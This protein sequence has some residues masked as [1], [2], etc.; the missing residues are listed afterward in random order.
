M[1]QDIFGIV[2]FILGLF[3][4]VFLLRMEWRESKVLKKSYYYNNILNLNKKFELEFFTQQLQFHKE[5]KSKAAVDKADLGAAA[6]QYVSENL[7]FIENLIQEYKKCENQYSNYKKEVNAILAT[8]VDYSKL[9]LNKFLFFSIDDYIKLE[10]KL[11][12]KIILKNKNRL[13]LYVYVDYTSPKGQNHW[14]KDYEYAFSGILNFIKIVKQRE[15]YM[16]SSKYQ[17][18]ILS[19]SL[20]YD[21][22]KKDNF[23]CRFCGASA[24]NDGVKLE[25]DHILPVSKGGKTEINNLQTLCERCNRGKSNKY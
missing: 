9:K 13:T 16:K 3:T 25:V 8:K 11:I 12:D 15:E 4:V 18:S 5:Y 2:I 20:R 6:V 1:D 24:K 21:V 7:G 17:R 14:Y 23:T 22:L 19:D 10:T